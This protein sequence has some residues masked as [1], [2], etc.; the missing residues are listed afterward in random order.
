MPLFLF[1]GI[2]PVL[3][4]R[5]FATSLVSAAFM[6]GSAV[7]MRLI[8]KDLD[9]RRA[10]ANV[11]VAAFILNPMVVY[12]AAN[13]MSEAPYLFFLILSVRYLAQ[14]LKSSELR[15]L[16]LGG[17]AMGFCYLVRYEVAA[18]APVA[19]LVV[20]AVTY[21][22][23][24]GPTKKR[25]ENGLVDAT[26]YLIPFIAAFVGWAVLSFVITGHPLEQFSSQYGN[27]A[28]IAATG[29]T[30]GTILPGVPT[31]VFGILQILA[32]APLLPL[33]VGGA[34]LRGWRRHDLR[35]LALL[36]FA[37]VVGFSW[38]EYV[39][40]GT[41]P[42]LRY[43]IPGVPLSLLAIGMLIN[44]PGSRLPRRGP[45]GPRVAQA[46]A[47]GAAVAIVVAP[48]IVTI[49]LAM[50]SANVGSIE[51]SHLGW[52]VNGHATDQFSRVNQAFFSSVDSITS[53]ID[54]HHY[55]SGSILMD[56]FSSCS[57]AIDVISR[58]PHQ[59]VITSDYDFQRTV[60]DPYA[61]HVR[62]ILVP[63]G[64]GA[65]GLDAVN[66]QYPALYDTGAHFAHEVKQYNTLG[67]P[68]FRL[69]RVD[70]SPATVG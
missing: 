29:G 24:E 41:Y 33:L 16:V 5:A 42:W 35:V 68:T 50:S 15:P 37:A 48:G 22:R 39:T 34:L 62:Y 3:T 13:G 7:Q 49:T 65:G 6:A 66:R 31:P 63:P 40:G 70:H 4:K 61:F 43:Y 10:S 8:L 51:Q 45:L 18:A 23:S 46:I 21:R 58:H 17:V 27:A 25:V 30:G 56:T 67:C 52:V 20:L 12:Y 64:G 1:K 55:P 53:D 54:A 19:A 57:W 59:F 26:V 28:Q 47:A 14:W 60:S 2:W 69:F 38:F 44:R 11:L 36:I 9:V 32:Y